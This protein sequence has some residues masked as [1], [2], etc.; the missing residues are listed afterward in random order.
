MEQ[1]VQMISMKIGKRRTSGNANLS[2]ERESIFSGEDS[3][4]PADPG[5]CP[6]DYFN[7]RGKFV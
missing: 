1:L 2:S 5:V 4:L 6:Y 7:S 3:D